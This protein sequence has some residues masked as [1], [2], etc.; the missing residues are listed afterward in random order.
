MPTT[1]A[2]QLATRTAALVAALNA[3]DGNTGEHSTR[4]CALA[5]ELAQACALAAAELATLTLAAQLHD[6]GKIGIPDSV[7]LKPGRL[8][9]DEM[10]VMR[11]HAQQGYEI[12]AAITDADVMPLALAVRHHHE[13]FDGKGY[14][15]GLCGEAIPLLS[16]IVA[17]ADSYDALATVRPYHKSRTHAEIMRMLH[18]DLG[19]KFDPWLRGKFAGVV[20]HSAY[21]ATA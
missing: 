3:R 6:I 19:G 7:L 16:R 15:D 8:D 10:T 21:R 14:P 9:A 20:E 5:V 12:L 1:N 2:S 4:S 18:E 17:I 11:S 13:S